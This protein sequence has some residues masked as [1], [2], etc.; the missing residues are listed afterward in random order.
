MWASIL[1]ITQTS[2]DIVQILFLFGPRFIGGDVFVHLIGVYMKGSG[3]ASKVMRQYSL[4]QDKAA[5]QHRVNGFSSRVFSRVFLPIRLTF[6]IGLFRGG[7]Y[8]QDAIF[9]QVQS[10]PRAET[11]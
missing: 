4:A 9:Q 1:S 10:W 7:P 8:L 6:L 3:G 2:L 11:G 5:C